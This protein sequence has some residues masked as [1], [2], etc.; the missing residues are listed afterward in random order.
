M[1]TILES[2]SSVT[3]RMGLILKKSCALC[4]DDPDLSR[5]HQ[6]IARDLQLL[7]FGREEEVRRY[8]GEYTAARAGID[9]R[10]GSDGGDSG[11]PG[12]G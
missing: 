8:F 1:N 5:F 6:M 11:R 10:R 12:I 3:D 2:G 4:Q 7:F 9:G